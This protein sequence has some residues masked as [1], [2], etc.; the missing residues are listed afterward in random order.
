MMGGKSCGRRLTVSLYRPPALGNDFRTE[1]ETGGLA[2]SFLGLRVS[3]LDFF[4]PLAIFAPFET[5]AEI[6]R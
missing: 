2:G 3:L 4:W 1:T 5:A 6:E